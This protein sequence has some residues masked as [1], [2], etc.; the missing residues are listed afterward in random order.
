MQWIR[1]ASLLPISNSCK[2]IANG[3]INVRIVHLRMID[4]I[5]HSVSLTK[6]GYGYMST[7]SDESRSP[8]ALP[9]RTTGRYSLQKYWKGVGGFG[10]KWPV[11]NLLQLCSNQLTC[12][13][14]VKVKQVEVKQVKIKL[15]KLNRWKF[16]RWKLNKWKLN[17]WKLNRWKLRGEKNENKTCEN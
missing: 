3:R 6:C 17:R 7:V 9:P 12:Q 11:D 15:W 14:K 4:N 10:E 2:F 1:E 13:L 5:I 16:N 8:R